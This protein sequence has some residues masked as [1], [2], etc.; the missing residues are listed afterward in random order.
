MEPNMDYMLFDSSGNTLGAYDD[1][2]AAHAA[3]R[4]VAAAEAEDIALLSYVDG[5]PVGEALYASEL[6][7]ATYSVEPSVWVLAN[8]TRACT[9]WTQANLW[10]P[11]RAARE[12]PL[13]IGAGVAAAD[14][15]EE[16]LR[17]HP[18]A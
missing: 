17:R 16:S 11:F 6:P 2:V 3:L 13:A 8:V 7:T 12:A 1:E 14:G 5:M 15:W 10:F 4:E 9:A 18:A